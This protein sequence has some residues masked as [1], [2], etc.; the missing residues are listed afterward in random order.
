[1]PILTKTL[2]ALK[3]FRLDDITD[4]GHT[5]IIRGTAKNASARCPVCG[6]HSRRVHSRYVRHVADL[7]LAGIAVTLHLRVRRF[8]CPV[9]SCP[10]R[11]F[12]ERFPDVVAP[13]GRRSQALRAALQQI[14]LAVGGE[15]GARLAW[16]LGMPTGSTSLLQLIRQLRLPD[17]GQPHAVG[18]DEWGAT[19]SRI[20]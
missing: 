14:A 19:R 8:F 18:I 10:R 12:T 15:G 2:P 16:R 1:M 20:A 6:R 17:P 4:N 3:Y 9:L 7:P 11:I 13:H 5:F